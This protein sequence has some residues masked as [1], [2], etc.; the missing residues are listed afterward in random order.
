MY[1]II[2]DDGLNVLNRFAM[3]K[4][5]FNQQRQQQIL[6]AYEELRRMRE[7]EKDEELDRLER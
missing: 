2:E 3:A 7:K 1:Q 6:K 5:K 4:K